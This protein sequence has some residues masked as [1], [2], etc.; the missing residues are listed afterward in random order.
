MNSDLVEYE[1]IDGN[2]AMLRLNRP[3]KLN[4]LSTRMIQQLVARLDAL[5]ADPAIRVV[6][7]TGAGTRAFAAGAD[8]DEYRDRQDNAFIKYQLNSREVFDRIEQLRLP[9]IAAIDGYALGG[10]FELALCCDV[11][12]VSDAARLGLPEGKIGLCPGGGGTQ[13]LTRTIGRHLT[14]DLLLS[15]RTLSGSRAYQIGLAAELAPSSALV[16][17]AIDKARYMTRLA[18]LAQTEMKRLMR[19]GVD[20]P[21]PVALTLEQE[22]LFRLYGTD[23]AQ[24]GIAAFLD[25]RPPNFKAQ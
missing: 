7:L 10:G 23:D 4:A 6:V 8:I 2:I 17:T 12:I 20:T 15:G 1:V 9:T 18:P 14:A 22:T 24:E 13:R 19:L 11:L 3:N 16:E 21:L 25:K 5:E